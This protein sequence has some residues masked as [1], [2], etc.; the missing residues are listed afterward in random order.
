MLIGKF[1]PTAHFYIDTDANDARCACEVKSRTVMA[2]A[3]F[4]KKT[5]V[6]ISTLDLNRRKKLVKCYI[7]STAL[8]SAETWTLR[9]T[10]LKYLESFEMCNWRRMEIS[11]TYHAGK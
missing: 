4:N 6:I 8:Y 9:K 3:A 2:K 7:G 10:E 5:T 11:V 1:A